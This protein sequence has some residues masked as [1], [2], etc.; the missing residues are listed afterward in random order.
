MLPSSPLDFNS[1]LVLPSPS[2]DLWWLKTQNFSYLPTKFYHRLF[3]LFPLYFMLQ[4][5]SISI[6]LSNMSIY[7]SRRKGT[8]TFD[9]TARMILGRATTRHLSAMV[10]Y[11]STKSAIPT[12]HIK[13]K[14][15]RLS[16]LGFRKMRLKGMTHSFKHQWAEPH[17]SFLTAAVPTAG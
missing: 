3:S 16:R 12:I 4:T 11:F 9:L 7:I 5:C 1:L 6:R 17:P 14:K 15:S 2:S 8:V 13:S 10:R